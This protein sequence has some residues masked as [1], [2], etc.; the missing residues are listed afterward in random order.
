MKILSLKKIKKFFFPKKK[1]VQA[2]DFHASFKK[3]SDLIDKQIAD[4]I[5]T[6]AKNGLVI[7]SRQAEHRI[8]NRNY[9]QRSIARKAERDRDYKLNQFANHS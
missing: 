8:K 3:L 6:C 1:E 2:D 7:N 9:L 4:E 5:S